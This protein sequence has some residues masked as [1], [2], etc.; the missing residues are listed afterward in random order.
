MGISNEAAA[1]AGFLELHERVQL[2]GSEPRI[3]FS[4][5]RIRVSAVEKNN[6]RNPNE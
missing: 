3:N 1:I 4:D 2:Q 6:V 5:R